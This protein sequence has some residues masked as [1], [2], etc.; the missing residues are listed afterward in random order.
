M[1]SLKTGK[2][3]EFYDEIIENRQKELAK[4]HN[5]KILDHSMI[6]YGEFL[7]EE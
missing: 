4:K 6:L 5:F 1:V 2:V 3:V 7:D